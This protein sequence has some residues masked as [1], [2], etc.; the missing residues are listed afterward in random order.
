MSGSAEAAT[1]SFGIIEA[2]YIET[3]CMSRDKRE[4]CAR[5]VY[6]TACGDRECSAPFGSLSEVNSSRL[7]FPVKV[8]FVAREARAPED[9]CPQKAP[10]HSG[11]AAV[12]AEPG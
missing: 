6:P 1:S 4:R 12:A 3:L 8:S 5:M 2:L 11:P 7:E 10:G 9:E